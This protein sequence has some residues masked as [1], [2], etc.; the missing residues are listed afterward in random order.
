MTLSDDTV[1]SG[2]E[3]F[4]L[5]PKSLTQCMLLVE[6]SME[7]MKGSLCDLHQIIGTIAHQME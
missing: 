7:G 6:D 4:S 3:P 5:S 2:L 1:Q